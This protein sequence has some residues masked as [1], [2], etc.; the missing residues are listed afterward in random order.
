MKDV[1][2]VFEPGTLSSVSDLALI[3]SIPIV[4]C[5]WELFP[6]YSIQGSRR[7]LLTPLHCEGAQSPRAG[8]GLALGTAGGESE[9]D[10]FPAPHTEQH[11][12]EIAVPLIT[13]RERSAPTSS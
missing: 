6:L 10:S 1:F 3:L 13:S 5:F 9:E 7:D 12:Q 4:M 8:N 2:L 11:L